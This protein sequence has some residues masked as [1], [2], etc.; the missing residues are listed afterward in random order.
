MTHIVNEIKKHPSQG[1]IISRI[2]RPSKE[3]VEKFKNFY[4]GIVLDAMGKN[5]CMHT[6]LGPIKSGMKVCGPAITCLGADL[7]VRRMAI[8]LA[9]VG[10]VLVVAAGGATD[11]ACFGDGTAKRMKIKGMAGA[12]IDGAIRDSAG[13][14]DLDFPTFAKG[15]TPKNHHYPL[16]SEYG[17]VNVPV[18]CGGILVNPGDLIIGDDDG[19]IVVPKDIIHK[20]ENEISLAFTEEQHLRGKWTQYEPFNVLKEL[21]SKGYEVE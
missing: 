13:I 10:D 18:V 19:V 8:D 15:V 1:K 7:S 21:I 11:F 17:A 4:T 9:N 6:D 3:M 20:I 5:G 14:K 12:V 2:D 16:A